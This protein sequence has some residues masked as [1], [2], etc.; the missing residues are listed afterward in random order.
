MQPFSFVVYQDEKLIKYKRKK[1]TIA[2]FQNHVDFPLKHFSKKSKGL[3]AIPRC[4][5]SF[6]FK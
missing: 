5:A 2:S 4:V 1:K 6:T 3:L